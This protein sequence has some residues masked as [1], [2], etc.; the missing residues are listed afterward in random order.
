MPEAKFTSAFTGQQ[1]ESAIKKAL[2]LTTF[3]FEHS[4]DELISGTIYHVLWITTPTD[5][6]QVKGFTI[7][8]NTGRIYE[9]FSNCKQLSVTR[10]VTEDDTI[11]ETDI[12]SLFKQLN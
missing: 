1:V 5:V 10:Y 12:E 8:P 3:E 9:V 6:N 11:Q 7:C 2:E 4:S